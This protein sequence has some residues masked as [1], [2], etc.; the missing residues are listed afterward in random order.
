MAQHVEIICLAGGLSSPF[1]FISVAEGL[2]FGGAVWVL[3]LELLLRSWFLTNPWFW[4]HWL[5]GLHVTQNSLPQSPPQFH[6]PMLH[7]DENPECKIENVLVTKKGQEATG[8]TGWEVE[9]RC[10][11]PVWRQTVFETDVTRSFTILFAKGRCWAPE[12]ETIGINIHWNDSCL[13]LALLRT[14]VPQAKWLALRQNT[15]F[16]DNQKRMANRL[17]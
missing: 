9:A 16:V 15:I 1:R 10:F 3:T 6:F 5:P 8:Y 17:G 14:R 2:G 11:S 13:W 7:R 4:K 12:W